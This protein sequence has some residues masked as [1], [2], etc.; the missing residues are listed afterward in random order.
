MP[1]ATPDGGG[2]RT[3][4]WPPVT[5]VV[6]LQPTS[7]PSTVAYTAALPLSWPARASVPPLLL[8]VPFLLSPRPTPSAPPGYHPA[9]SASHPSLPP[10]VPVD[11]ARLSSAGGRK[12]RRDPASR[13]LSPPSVALCATAP[14]PAARCMSSCP[15]S[16]SHGFPLCLPLAERD[17]DAHQTVTKSVGKRNPCRMGKENLCSCTATSIDP[18]SATGTVTA[19][20]PTAQTRTTRPWK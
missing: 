16:R 11:F 10:P 13:V 4:K 15:L 20:G 8:S 12:H 3:T 6:S 18:G 14:P 5:A 2:G 7:V 1:A 9:Q 17:A 19:T